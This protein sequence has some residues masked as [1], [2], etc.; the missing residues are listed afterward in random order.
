MKTNSFPADDLGNV[1]SDGVWQMKQ[2]RK[3]PHYTTR[4]DEVPII[5]LVG[6]SG[7]SV[8]G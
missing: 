5:N 1:N 7:N 2:L 4:I 6:R 3:S 8:I